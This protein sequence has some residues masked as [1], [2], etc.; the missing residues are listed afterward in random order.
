MNNQTTAQRLQPLSGGRKTRSAKQGTL[1]LFPQGCGKEL[2]MIYMTRSDLERLN[3]LREDVRLEAEALKKLQGITPHTAEVIPL[4]K[5]DMDAKRAQMEVERERVQ[6]YVDEI[7]DPITRG[8]IE[9]H[10]LNGKPWYETAW[11]AAQALS[12]NSAWNKAMRYIYARCGLC[13]KK[14]GPRK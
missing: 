14:R 9:D 11:N 2:F 1:A 7:K 6:R 10:Y 4:I 3:V 12:T 5:A 8:I 13:A